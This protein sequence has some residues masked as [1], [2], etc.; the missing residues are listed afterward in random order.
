MAVSCGGQ[1]GATCTTDEECPSHFC[2]ADGTCGEAEIDAG[3][4]SADAPGDG[5]SGLCTPN[6][7]GMIALA[8]LPLVA[9]RSAKFRIATNA[10]LDTAGTS[11]G[12]G[13]RVWN[14]AGQLANDSDETIALANPMGT[15]WKADF[16]TATY[17]APLAAGSDLQGVFLV[18]STGVT[19]LGVVSP[20]GG[21]Y[22]TELE[23]DPPARILAVPFMA[24]STWSTTS[25]VSGYAQGVI[26]AY[27]EKY[28]SRV[29]QVGTMTTP[30]GDFPAMR[31]ATDLTRTSGLALLLSKRSFAWVAECFGSVATVQ[32][33]DFESSSE[34]SEAAE[35]RRLAP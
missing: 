35:V 11:Q 25:T 22:K 29:D 24:G 10:M 2:K 12:S 15:W 13:S 16:P 1:T 32:S 8:E 26:V 30:Y 21:T 6:H 7:D 5:M 33:K 17:A 14:L 4:G 18:D 20:Q 28:E 31:V 19:M 23:Y 34:F 9:G 3:D 27:T